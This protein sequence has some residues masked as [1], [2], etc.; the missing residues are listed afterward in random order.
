M[1]PIQS[2]TR[3]IEESRSIAA[4]RPA[5]AMQQPTSSY[6]QLKLARSSAHGARYYMYYM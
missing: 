6:M 1:I 4:P 5:T 3:S 2:S